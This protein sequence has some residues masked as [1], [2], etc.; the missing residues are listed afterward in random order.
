MCISEESRQVDVLQLSDGVVEY[1]VEEHIEIVEVVHGELS[2]SCDH[3]FV[4]SADCGI[5]YVVGTGCGALV[6]V[7]LVVV[8]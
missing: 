1:E 3:V 4:V 7:C 5:Q 2:S 6:F 8:V